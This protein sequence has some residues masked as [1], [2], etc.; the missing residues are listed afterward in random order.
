MARLDGKAVVITGASSG[1]GE[2]LAREVVRRGGRVGLL[3][4]R[5]ER[6]RTLAEELRSK[7]GDPDR[8]AWAAADVSDGD[9]LSAGLD[10]LE[11][12]LGTVDVVVANAGYSL[13]EKPREHKPG[14]A[15]TLYD[16]N[17]LGLLRVIDW[18]LPRF[19]ERGSGHIVGVA[20][21]ASFFG[22]PGMSAYCGSKAAMRV[23][24]QGLRVALKKHGVRVTCICPGFVKSELTDDYKGT[25]PF[26]WETD[27]AARRMADGIEGNEA[28]TAFPW[29]MH[30]FTRFVAML[31]TA[32]QD[33]LL[34]GSR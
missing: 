27:R 24:L 12:S 17:L 19:V 34:A 31:P 32:L 25:M 4:R 3:A 10:R 8:A 22:A 14:K 6:L 30:A 28:L 20:S 9:A 5:E 33:K 18:A 11:E 21:L 26:L 15:V 13:V 1:L 7:T 16:V 29:Q 2:H 23:H